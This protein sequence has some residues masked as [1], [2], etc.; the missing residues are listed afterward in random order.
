MYTGSKAGWCMPE[1]Q[2]IWKAEEEGLQDEASL[3]NIR[4]STA[5]WDTQ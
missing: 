1:I 4:S 5:A 3:Y 2:A